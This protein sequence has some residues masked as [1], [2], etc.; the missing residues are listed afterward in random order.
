M[1]PVKGTVAIDSGSELARLMFS[2]EMKTV[3]GSY[4]SIRAMNDFP[5]MTERINKICRRLKDFRAAGYE[6][7]FIFHEG[8][9][10][11]YVR[12]SVMA[13]KG[14]NNEPTAVKGRI[15][16]PGQVAPEEV[17]RVGDNIFRVRL[18]NGQPVWV[19][20]PEPIGPGAPEHWQVKDRFNA[21]AN[22][23][24]YL[25]SSYSAIV[26]QLKAKGLYEQYWDGPYIWMI[27]GAVGMKKTLSL[28]S[29]PKPIR[30]FDL[31]IGTAVLRN[32]IVKDP[33]SWNITSYNSE[34]MNEYG[35]FISDFES[36]LAVPGE[37][38]TVKAKLGIKP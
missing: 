10:K 38:A 35:R 29:F 28:A 6:C 21:E 37:V 30:V 27:Y 12:G 4:E 3:P 19:C 36:V 9:D 15:D 26:A 16:M 14:Q 22:I 33:A 32:E 31:D 24:A 11:V 5:G 20:K 7:V 1:K 18:V 13:K 23:G 34:D 25:P 8:I 17:M 2:W